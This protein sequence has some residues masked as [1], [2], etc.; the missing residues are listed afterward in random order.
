MAFVLRFV[1]EF[2]TV[3]VSRRFGILFVNYGDGNDSYREHGEITSI[4]K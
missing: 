1:N 4:K 2:F 3:K